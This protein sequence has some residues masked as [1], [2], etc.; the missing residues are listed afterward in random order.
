MAQDAALIAKWKKPGFEHL[1]SVDPGWVANAV[2]F[3][4]AFNDD[5]L[6]FLEV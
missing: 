4:N 5:R 2:I 3:W 6:L 1:V